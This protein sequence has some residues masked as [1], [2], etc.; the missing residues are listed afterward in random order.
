VLEVGAGVAGLERV[1]LGEPRG[2]RVHRLA[3]RERL[4][5]EA[6]RVEVAG[7][8]ALD[9]VAQN[10]DQPRGRKRARDPFGAPRM[11]EVVRRRLARAR[12]PGRARKARPVP[13][14]ALRKAEVEVVDLLLRGHPEGA[15]RADTVRDMKPVQ[16]LKWDRRFL[17]LSDVIARWSKDPSRGVG[18]VI[19]SPT[20]QIV[21]TG[22]NGLPRGIEDRPERL[23][24]P[25]KYDLIVHAEMN[26]I[27]QCARNGV[28]PVGA[29]IYTSFSPCVHCTLSIIQSGI[30][31]V[32]TYRPADG[33][34]HWLENF[35]KSN[36]LLA[37]SG[38]EYVEL[39]RA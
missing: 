6:H 11:E 29:T 3:D 13:G 12:A 9:R 25:V 14:L 34:A 38:V 1:V 28:S 15:E 20:R 23:E 30:V 8:R 10:N 5:P 31:R 2:L 33:D 35:A 39:E 16:S 27:V 26:A 24:R 22:F 21:A 4:L 36:E 17:E 18:A 7:D 32:V 37:E 19:V